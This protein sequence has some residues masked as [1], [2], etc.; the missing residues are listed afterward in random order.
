[1]GRYLAIDLGAESGRVMLG[2]LAR[3]R[4]R[5]RELHRFGNEPRKVAGSLRWDVERIFREIKIGL[6]K[7]AKLG[8][9]DGI[10]CDSWGVDYVAIRKSEGMLAQPFTYRDE[11]TH[12]AFARL[13]AKISPQ[14]L[15]R[16]TGIGCYSINTLNQLFDDVENRPALLRNAD[17][18]LLIA[19]YI[20]WM[21]TGIARGEETLVSGTQCWD[22]RTRGWALGLLA[23]AGIPTHI[24][25][26]P[27]RP[28]TRLGPLTDSVA[29]ETKLTKTSVI[30]VC[31]HD[32]A[33]A[34]AAVPASGRNWAYLSSGT[35][36]LLGV[37]LPR[38]IINEHAQV[39]NF[40]NE[41]GFGSST[42]FLKCLV[43]L[44]ILQEARKDW[45]TRDADY[46]RIVELARKSLPLVS[47]IRPDAPEFAR[48]GNMCEKIRAY[49]RRT[50]QPV[51]A[52]PGAIARCIFESLALLY[53]VELDQLEQLT[54][55]KLKVLHIVGGGSQNGMLNQLTADA[56]ERTVIAGPA[57]ATAIGNVLVQ[58]IATKELAGLAA[59]RA[60]VAHSF[61]PKTYQ[62]RAQ[63]RWTLARERFASLPV[64][65]EAQRVT[66][67]GLSKPAR[68][69]A[70]QRI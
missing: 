4:V 15:Y 49:C 66:L 50:D 41:T 47:L 35:W 31:G 26:K 3:G 60:V 62:P 70:R 10:G 5:I 48:P 13:K 63:K 33:S 64:T 55:R 65:N 30:T 44:W 69:A 36:S 52:S 11:R 8:P 67:A 22:V 53:R 16:R 7:A 12:R 46:K 34:I 2:V 40:T 29:R 18:I 42:C 21:L 51:P 57:E 56:L 27:I 14:E 23:K 37:E 19:D 25:P 43:G 59:L 39:A 17:S 45:S 6:R 1:M 24:L 61:R 38:P 28:A 32:T 58:A 9:I 20:N 54:Q 68:K